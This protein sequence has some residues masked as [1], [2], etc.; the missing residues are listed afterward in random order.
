MNTKN[1]K[2]ITSISFASEGK[3]RE[4]AINRITELGMHSFS[5]Y[6]KQL[7]K[8]DLGLPNYIHPY[9][10][11]S[12]IEYK[13]SQALQKSLIEDAKRKSQKNHIA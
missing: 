13:E 6:V 2:N 5:E 10:G 3:L 4:M 12:L 1:P 7:I 8:Y 11:K 9:V